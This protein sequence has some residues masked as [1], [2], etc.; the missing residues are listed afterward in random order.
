MGDAPRGLE[1]GKGPT[2]GAYPDLSEGRL[3]HSK[4]A[5][6][7]IGNMARPM[8][9][10]DGACPRRRFAGTGRR[11]HAR[12]HTHSR[13]PHIPENHSPFMRVFARIL[14]RVLLSV[15]ETATGVAR[16]CARFSR[17]SLGPPVAGSISMDRDA[18]AQTAATRT[19]ISCVEERQARASRPSNCYLHR[20]TC[21]RP[22]TYPPSG[23]TCVHAWAR[24]D[25]AL[26]ANRYNISSGCRV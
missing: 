9:S 2:R 20:S 18:R 19:V 4:R 25:R 13:I 26:I 3:V 14:P 24:M 16:E 12:T 8:A 1:G 17:S 5:K 11:A 10:L 23:H 7:C 21:L 15:E 22:T 6:K